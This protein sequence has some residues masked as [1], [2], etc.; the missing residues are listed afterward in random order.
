MQRQDG[1]LIDGLNGHEPHRRSTDSFT[2]RLRIGGVVLIALDVGLDELWGD[3]LDGM[4]KSLQLAGPMMPTAASLE[5]NE[6]WF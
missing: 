2:N 6:A 3:Q 1:L 5:A 4:P